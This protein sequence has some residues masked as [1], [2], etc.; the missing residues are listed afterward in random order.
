MGK[1]WHTNKTKPKAYED[2]I[3]ID[4]KGNVW[5]D[6]MQ[7]NDF[8][9]NIG[10]SECPFEDIVLWQYVEQMFKKELAEIRST[11]EIKWK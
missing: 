9:E 1:K 7:Q 10:L 3:V 5:T 2:I 4:K 6:L 11:W 8:G